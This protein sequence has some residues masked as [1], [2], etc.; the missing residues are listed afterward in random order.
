MNIRQCEYCGADYKPR[1]KRNRYC[2]NDC[3]VAYRESKRVVTT[4][5]ACNIEFKSLKHEGRKFCGSS[6]AATFN[7]KVTPKK[8]PE[9][10]C[11]DCKA[12]IPKRWTYCTDCRHPGKNISRVCH[13]CGTEYELNNSKS[14]FC[15]EKCR[16][17]AANERKRVTYKTK[18]THADRLVCQCGG[19]KSSQAQFCADCRAR[20]IKN[21]RIASWLSGEW[22]GGTQYGLSGTIRNH[23][24]EQS[25]YKCSKCGFNTP[26]PD[27]NKTILE[28]N[29]ING[30]GTDH[31]PENLEVVCPNCHALTSSYRG[32]NQGNGRPQYYLRRNKNVRSAVNY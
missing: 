18:D 8:Q 3:Y 31:S 21:D 7:N 24:L 27:D 1:K 10:E 23:L 28:I 16:N 2:G 14:K 13:V 22:A 19:A 15:S 9:G 26:H 6:C 29:H 5:L 20:M 4:C 30:D 12:S 17:I 11:R 32:R 25:D